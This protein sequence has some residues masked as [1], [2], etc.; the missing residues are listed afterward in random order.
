MA[1]GTSPFELLHGLPP[2]FSLSA[3]S[4]LYRAT[5]HIQRSSL[6]IFVLAPGPRNFRQPET[7]PACM[8]S[9]LPFLRDL[10]WHRG[11]VER[12]PWHRFKGVFLR[13]RPFPGTRAVAECTSFMP[14]PRDCHSSATSFCLGSEAP[15]EMDATSHTRGSGS[16]TRLEANPVSLSPSS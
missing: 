6:A 9:V 15:T 3:A 4:A 14:Y 16:G 12:A 5:P 10:G 8:K 11:T 2:V 7:R 1:Q 13:A